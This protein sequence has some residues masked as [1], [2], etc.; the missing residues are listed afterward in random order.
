[1]TVPSS[2]GLTPRSLSRIAFSMAASEPLSY[3]VMV[4]IRASCTWKEAICGIGVGVP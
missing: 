3:G 2:V 1:M 4:T